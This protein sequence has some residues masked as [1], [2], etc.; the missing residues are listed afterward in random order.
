MKFQF[1]AIILFSLLLF[2]SCDNEE[3]ETEWVDVTVI[4]EGVD[5]RENWEIEY[6]NPPANSLNRFK[7][8]GLPSEYKTEGLELKLKIRDPKNE[9]SFPCTT[10]GISYPFKVI[11][12][13]KRK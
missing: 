8:I 4:G 6:K 13:A 7:E 9:E 1:Y 11:M 5:C 3:L 12:E 10:L 2:V